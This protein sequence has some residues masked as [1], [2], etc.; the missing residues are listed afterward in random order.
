MSKLLVLIALITLAGCSV[1]PINTTTTARSLG[2]D[3]NQVTGN[4]I[5]TGVQY[6][7]GITEKL[8]LN[9]GMESQF[10]LVLNAYAKYSFKNSAEKGFSFAG[11]GGAGYGSDLGHSK[12][13]YTRIFLSQ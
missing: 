5:A 9:V 12:S 1:A 10:G 2:K 11:I 4:A 3:K 8:D 6:A 7:R 13:L